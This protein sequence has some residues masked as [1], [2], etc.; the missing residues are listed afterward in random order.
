MALA[1]YSSRMASN[2]AAAASGRSVASPARAVRV[3]RVEPRAAAAPGSSSSRGSAVLVRSSSTK[4]QE[5]EL[6]W[7]QQVKDGVVMN[8]SNKS[9]GEV[10]ASATDPRCAPRLASQHDVHLK[11]S[12]RQR[13]ELPGP[14]RE[15]RAGLAAVGMASHCPARLQESA[16]TGVMLRDVVC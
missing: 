13:P 1:Q 16:C 8:V 9:A 2:A 11:C 12:R 5:A 4:Q 7:T 3:V 6:R 15:G 10:A 14:L